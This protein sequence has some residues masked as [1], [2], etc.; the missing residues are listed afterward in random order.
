MSPR[1][2]GPRAAD[3][4]AQVD[5]FIARM[6][7]LDPAHPSALSDLAELAHQARRA[8]VGNN[9]RKARLERAIDAQ[10]ERLEGGAS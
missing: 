7:A 1:Y 9:G 5:G 4:S 8:A 2:D 6:E 10:R 3:K